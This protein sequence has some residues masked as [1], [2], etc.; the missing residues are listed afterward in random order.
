MVRYEATDYRSV[1]FSFPVG[2]IG[3]I[4]EL[5]S[6]PNIAGRGSDPT[7]RRQRLHIRAQCAEHLGQEPVLLGLHA[8][9]VVAHG[10]EPQA[11]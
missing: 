9:S 6:D 4:A 8:A 5:V 7:L 2:W 10:G 3:V 11:A 1:A